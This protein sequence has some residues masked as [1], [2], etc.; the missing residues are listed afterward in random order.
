MVRVRYLFQIG[1]FSL[2]MAH[3]SGEGCA[4][5][6][7]FPKRHPTRRV[8]CSATS[9]CYLVLP[10]FAQ[11][12]KPAS[13]QKITKT[14]MSVAQR[15]NSFTY[16]STCGIVIQTVAVHILHSYNRN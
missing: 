9:R 6:E 8:L 7:I 12:S 13:R 10:Q 1:A 15:P 11:I 3:Y 14:E 2:A 16:L 5:I 4:R